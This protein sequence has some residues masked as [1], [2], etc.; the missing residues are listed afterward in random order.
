M[1][2][3]VILAVGGSFRMKDFNYFAAGDFLPGLVAKNHQK[4]RS[5]CLVHEFSFT[6]I[7][8]EINH[9]RKILCGCFRSLWLWLLITIAVIN[10]I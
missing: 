5:S 6:D 3:F 8:N 2:F 1:I 4:F 7:F 10:L 9:G